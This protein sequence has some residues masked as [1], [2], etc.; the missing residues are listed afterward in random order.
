M[1]IV[2]PVVIGI[3]AGFVLSGCQSTA[4][5]VSRTSFQVI[6]PPE[7]LLEC[8]Q[9]RRSE[10]PEIDTLT[11]A[12]VAAVVT[13]LWSNNRT[14]A[15]NMKLIRDYVREAKSRVAASNN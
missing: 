7:R 10:I 1:R 2:V 12:Q 14:C 3:V 15:Q 8:P 4:A 13:K 5:V 6:A 9:L 11:N